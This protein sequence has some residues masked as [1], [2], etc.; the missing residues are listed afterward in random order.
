MLGSGRHRTTKTIHIEAATWTNVT[1]NGRNKWKLYKQDI[2]P[3][4]PWR[5]GKVITLI[6]VIM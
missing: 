3:L 1:S 4:H 6:H 5:V 2:K